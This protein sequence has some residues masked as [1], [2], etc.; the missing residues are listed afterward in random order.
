MPDGRQ[1][2]VHQTD[3][4]ATWRDPNLTD[5]KPLPGTI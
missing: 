4:G 5:N 2:L 3:Q 1:F